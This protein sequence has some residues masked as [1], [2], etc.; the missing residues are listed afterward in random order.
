MFDLHIHSIYSDGRATVDQ[1]VRKAKERGLKTIAIV[2]H[3]IEHKRGITEEKLKKRQVEIERAK[4]EYGLE[5]L[6]GVE[7]GILPNGEIAIPDF[8]FDLII[9][10]I[11]DI[12]YTREYYERI[13]NCL[14]KYGDRI[15]VLG[16]LH[17]DLFSCG[18]DHSKDIE[19]LDLLI[20]NDIA[21]EIN[22]LHHAPP[23]DLLEICSD[24]RIKYSIGSDAHSVDRVGDVKWCLE[25]AKR[26]LK[27]G[28]AI[29]DQ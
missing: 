20:E 13:I 5:V 8:D 27:K 1:I 16:H 22:S 2:D 29:F 7:C 28:K 9:A 3:S 14:E 23:L 18:R 10:S 19:I 6:S 24:L 4:D 15:D 17:S 21:L 26:F 11:H 12:L 25:M